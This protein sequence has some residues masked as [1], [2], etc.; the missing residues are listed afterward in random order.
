MQNY[1]PFLK[2]EDQLNRIRDKKII[3]QNEE[4]AMEFLRNHSYY[5][6]INGY[7]HHFLEPGEHDLMVPGTTFDNF[8]AVYLIDTNI[9]NLIFKHILFIEKGLR[10]R[11][12]YLIGE[13]IGD[14]QE[15][16]TQ[17]HF[18]SDRKRMRRQVLEEIDGT[19]TNCGANSNTKYFKDNKDNIPPWIILYDVSF[20]T[21]ISWYD[22]LKDSSYRQEIR[23]DYFKNS[24]LFVQFQE[25]F[26]FKSMHFLRE[27]RNLAAHGKRNFKEKINNELPIESALHFFGNLLLTRQDVDLGIGTKDLYAVI[28]LILKYTFDPELIKSFVE[29]LIVI[30][31]PYIDERSFQPTELINGKSIYSILNVPEDLFHRIILFLTQI[32]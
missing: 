6:L 7:K 24:N 8:K 17:R 15:D 22:I 23:L 20:F 5:T 29:E 18:Y 21:A 10:S 31:L 16:Y 9:H 26:F 27:Y 28:I 14:S 3:V 25:K 11:L 1:I 30:L 13:K 19:I 2:F 32:Q 12:A 4:S